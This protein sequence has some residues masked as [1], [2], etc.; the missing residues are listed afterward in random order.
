M[1]YPGSRAA[2]KTVS[3]GLSIDASD[4]HNA[5]V[6]DNMSDL[7][8]KL[9]CWPNPRLRGIPNSRE[10]S[11]SL[12]IVEPRLGEYPFQYYDIV[13]SLPLEIVL[14]IVKYLNPTD[15]I[16][17]RMVQALI[18]NDFCLFILSEGC[19]RFQNYGFLFL[20]RCNYE[21]YFSINTWI[22]GRL[23]YT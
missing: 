18:L 9:H 12:D 11:K 5:Y 20:V 13:G 22:L 16:R 2:P 4:Y 8:R 23:R 21:G 15:V 14:L 3:A 10:N 7:T 6:K 19:T 1:K 17:N